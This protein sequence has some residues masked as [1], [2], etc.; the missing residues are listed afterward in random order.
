L[1]QSLPIV[2]HESLDSTNEEAKRQ[3]SGNAFAQRWIAA[4][5]QT[6][7]RGRLGRQ[8]DSPSGNL[9]ATALISVPGGVSDALRLPFA[10]A[11]AV[12]DTVSAFAGDEGLALKWPNDVRVRGAKICGILV[13]FGQGETGG[14]AAVGI[15]IN[16]ASRPD[17][18]EQAA[19]C[20]AELCDGP[21]PSPQIVLEKL[22]ESFAERRAQAMSDFGRVRSDWCARAEGRDGLVRARIGEDVIEGQFA[23]LAED[24]GLLLDLPGGQRRTIRAGDVELVRQV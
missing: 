13:E 9:F 24:G 21:V 12:H 1:S 19:T 6:A 15:G 22:A 23:G 11:L 8:W 14:W 10:A 2:W 5:K 18:L 3:A 20:M 4:R 7:G 16:V 17:G